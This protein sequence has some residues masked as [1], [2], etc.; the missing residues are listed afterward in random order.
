MAEDTGQA[1]PH[2]QGAQR[3]QEGAVHKLLATLH[4]SL[5]MQE[6]LLQDERQ[7]EEQ[8]TEAGRLV[9]AQDALLPQSRTG[10][11]QHSMA[12]VVVRRHVHQ[13][14]IL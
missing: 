14:Y 1:Q 6:L 9:E 13:V 12:P 2:G 8:R 5:F 7:A 10:G 11:R 4:S 3:L